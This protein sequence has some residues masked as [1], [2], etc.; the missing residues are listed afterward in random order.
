MEQKDYKL[1]IVKILLKGKKHVRQIAREIG[2]NHMTIS[3]RMQ[4]LFRDNVVDFEQEG[5]NKTYFLKK[6]IEARA[7]VLMTEQYKLIQT[8]KKYPLLQ[9][10]IERIRE[11]KQVRLAILFGSYA[12]ELARKDSDIDVYIETKDR[13]LKK[14]LSLI[15]TRLSIKIGK[16]DKMSNLIKEIDKNHVIIKGNEEYYEKNQ[17]FS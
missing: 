13:E 5:K 10:V 1:E 11:D 6:T 8:L 16:Y 14:K 7:Y 2:T 12:K 17:F 15:D 4:E 9:I 3:R